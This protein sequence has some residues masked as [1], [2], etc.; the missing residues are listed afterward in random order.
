M[1][2]SNTQI[3][4]AAEQ[5]SGVAEELN[6]SVTGI[7]DVTEQTVTQTAASANTST[8]LAALSSELSKAIQQFKL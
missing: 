7:R 6:R 5:Q 4:D 3:A 2:E 1:R 8:E